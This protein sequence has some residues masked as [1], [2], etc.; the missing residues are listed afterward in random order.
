MNDKNTYII[1][2]CLCENCPFE[3][4]V[5]I[6]K[7]IKLEEAIC[8]NCGNKNGLYRKPKTSSYYTIE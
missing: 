7:G 4:D 6:T 1:E 3:G 2:D 5:E 8:P